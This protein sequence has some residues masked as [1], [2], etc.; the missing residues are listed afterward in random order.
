MERI[1]DVPNA[2]RLPEIVRNWKATVEAFDA[3]NH[4]VHGRD[5]YT[6]N[7]AAPK[8]EALL[9]AVA[10]VHAYSLQNGVDLGAR[11]R[12]RRRKPSMT[13]KSNDP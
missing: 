1:E 5:R 8:V 11:L 9:A 13:V 3:R 4:L 10:D 2:R 6:R 12:V 7:M